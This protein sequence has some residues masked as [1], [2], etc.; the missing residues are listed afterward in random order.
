MDQID[1]Y[2]QLLALTEETSPCGTWEWIVG[3][4]VFYWSA[5]LY[6]ILGV[7]PST[8]PT[9]ELYTRLVH[10]EDRL[11]FSNPLRVATDGSMGVRQFRVLRDDGSIRVIRSVGRLL[12]SAEGEPQRMIG[13]A[14][15][16]TDASS[17]LA[18]LRREQFVLDA[19]QDLVDVS[20]WQAQPDG[21]V[22]EFDTWQGRV[23][24]KVL[25]PSGWGRFDKLHPD[26][27]ERVAHAWQDA[28][29]SR[30]PFEQS[31]RVMSAG[32]EYRVRS[33]AV[34]LNGPTG[35][36][37]WLGVTALADGTPT[38]DPPSRKVLTPALIRGARALLDWTL[39]DL[40]N[41][42]GVSV[43]SIRRAEGMLRKEVS[44]STLDDL[45]R[46]F[47]RHGIRFIRTAT[48]LGLR[49]QRN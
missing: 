4:S 46:T 26:D 44:M 29:T 17:A 32:E 9:F 31:Y 5:G 23:G 45:M 21:R 38:D 12:H 25:P 43:S 6:R 10:P 14:F 20:T 47:E 15:D 7:D 30:K 40:A 33:R 16:V 19:V 35:S 39:N 22:V 1:L 41:A 28:V 2:R 42:S 37:G 3:A 27:Q 24:A 48:E 36:L 8:P 11:D 13:V 18:A 34:T 49:L